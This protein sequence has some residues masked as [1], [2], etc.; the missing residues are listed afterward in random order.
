MEHR[1]ELSHEFDW[2][3]VKILDNESNLSKRLTPEIIYTKWKNDLNVQNNTDLLDLIQVY[4][5][6]VQA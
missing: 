5:I 6:F 1:Q 3:N 4:Y 2:D